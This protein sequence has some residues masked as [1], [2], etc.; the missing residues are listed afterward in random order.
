MVPGSGRMAQ[1]IVE[2][3]QRVPETEGAGRIG[4]DR[5]A[6]AVLGE[7]VEGVC[8]SLERASGR[9]V[10]GMIEDIAKTGRE[11][12]AIDHREQEKNRRRCSAVLGREVATGRAS[13]QKVVAVEAGERHSPRRQDMLGSPT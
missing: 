11:A 4:S 13:W 10:S 5:T 8:C 3:G 6:A 1:A 9:M 2:A 7:A 12:V